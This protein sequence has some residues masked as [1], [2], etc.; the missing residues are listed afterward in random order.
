M[1]TDSVDDYRDLVKL[2]LLPGLGPRL[3]AA[4]LARFGSARGVLEAT[5][6]ELLEVPHIGSKLADSLVAAM[7]R[8]DVQAELDLI[9]REQVSLLAHGQPG[10]PTSLLQLRDAP[11]LLYLK[12]RLEAKDQKA[13]AIVGSRHCTGYGR[14]IAEQLATGLAAHG[15]TVISGLARGIDG[16]AHQAALDAGGRTL[17]VVAGGLARIYP[18]EHKELAQAV[19]RS[20]AVLTEA[21]MR[22]EPMAAMFPARNRLISA[23]S[24]AVVIVEAAEKSGALITARHAADQGRPVFAVPGP[25]DSVASSGTN[26][27][28]RQGA[29]LIRS[30]EDVR[31][32]LEG[33]KAARKPVLEEKPQGLDG[34]QEKIWALLAQRPCHVD[35][36]AQE[37]GLDISRISTA[38]MTMELKKLVR[39]LPGN[40]YERC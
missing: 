10:Y 34:V 13:V 24:L 16:L 19:A 35:V 7:G 37:L 1:Q 22:M 21:N 28:I 15:Y 9:A 14:R 17:A 3:T 4:L 29:I 8:L 2:H 6:S 26:H 40:Q 5:T 31:E 20:G 12:G 18:P 25:V 27:L 11:T 23:L 38:L 33:I 36:M 39:R 32:E 30:V